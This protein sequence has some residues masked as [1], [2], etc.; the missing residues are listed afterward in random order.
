[1]F[2]GTFEH[3]IDLKGRMTIPA[4]FRDLIVDGAYMTIGFE[5]NLMILKADAFEK[6]SDTINK[7]SVTN[8]DARDLR[9]LMFS[10]A[11][12]VEIDKA[13]RILIPTHLR[14]KV[15]LEDQAVVLGAGSY[16]EIWAPV[17]WTPRSEE[18]L[19]GEINSKR[20]EALELSL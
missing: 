18:L 7:L 6:L 19:S 2:L 12:E 16:F 5:N 20:F 8:A 13:G 4:R 15:Q 10:H 17:L 3:T 1:M 9:R 14:A 11:V